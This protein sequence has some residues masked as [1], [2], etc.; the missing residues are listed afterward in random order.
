MVV[1]VAGE[2]AVVIVAGEIAVVIVAGEHLS[3]CFLDF[4]CSSAA[5]FNCHILF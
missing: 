5:K 2:I 3:F 4:L 1:I